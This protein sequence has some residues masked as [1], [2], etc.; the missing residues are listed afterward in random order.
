MSDTKSEIARV[1]NALAK[2]QS[3]HL[4]RDYEKYLKKLYKRLQAEKRCNDAI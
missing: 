1:E 4:K 2:T 3:P